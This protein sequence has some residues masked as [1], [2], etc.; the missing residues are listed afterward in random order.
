M[1]L[2]LLPLPLQ[3]RK[4]YGSFLYIFCSSSSSSFVQ[5]SASNQ[6][7]RHTHEHKYIE[8]KEST[9][10]HT[11]NTIESTSDSNMSRQMLTTATVAQQRKQH[12]QK[13]QQRSAQRE[14]EKSPIW[15]CKK[16]EYLTNTMDF[17]CFAN[18]G[19]RMNEELS[20]KFEYIIK[21]SV[22]VANVCIVCIRCG[23]QVTVDTVDFVCVWLAQWWIRLQSG[24]PTDDDAEKRE[25]I[26]SNSFF[27]LIIHW[28][29]ALWVRRA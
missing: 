17:V 3:E 1:L 13:Q 15:P 19:S 29:S 22:C 24:Q 27:L 6:N 14:R 9:C 16:K 18:A 23:H 20:L 11:H 25:Y 8:L 5:Q 7:T 26:H 2:L 10:T 21:L 28:R 12:R 4:V